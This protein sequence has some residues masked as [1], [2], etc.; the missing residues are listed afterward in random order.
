MA[1]PETTFGASI[2]PNSHPASNELD[3]EPLANE[4]AV[5]L[6][7]SVSR[8]SLAASYTEHRPLPPHS[9]FYQHPPASHELVDATH[10]RN[11]NT[12]H[13]DV[14]ALEKHLPSGDVT[15]LSATDEN[16]FC[17]KISVGANKECTMWPSRQ[18]LVQT[19]M[20]EKKQRW[21]SRTCA[22]GHL[23]HRWSTMHKRQRL[24]IRL[25]IGLLLVG[26]MI[27]IGVGIS[28]A[29]HG[30]YYSGNGNSTSTR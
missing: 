27:G 14:G 16:P 3:K 17:S 4:G 11:P 22:C 26:A 19:K 15:P 12:K 1:P 28:R 5:D 21:A 8:E 6:T 10:G 18:T 23:Q 25:A 13:L 24:L 2:V 7:P 29:V 30:S 9:P 20:A